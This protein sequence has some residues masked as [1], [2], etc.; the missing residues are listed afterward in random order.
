VKAPVA[1]QPIQGKTTTTSADMNG[2]ED[3]NAMNGVP[4]VWTAG[5]NLS[6]A[7]AKACGIAPRSDGRA[8][9]PSFEFDS[10]SLGGEDRDLL[11]QIAKCVTE[12]ALKGK[13]LKLL[14]RADPRGEP[15]YN[16][17]LGERR[18]DAVK[19]YLVDLG[20][21]R[22]KLKA[23]SRGAMDATGKDEAGWALDRR[24]DVE[25]AD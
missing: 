4:L 17:T 8:Y 25:L 15:E 20:A 11:A 10:A 9:A 18:A 13:G 24:V 14:G 5:L 2:G 23:T 12:G 21:P 19:R 22:D 6:N 16:M 7:I 3:P 1:E